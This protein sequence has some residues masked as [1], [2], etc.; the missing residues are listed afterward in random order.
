MAES[1][2]AKDETEGFALGTQTLL[3]GLFLLE[4]VGA[5]MS[6]IRTL[7]GRLGTPRTTTHR[8]LAN[9]IKAGY[10]R[11]P[12]PGRYILGPKIIALGKQ[13]LEQ[14]PLLSVAR[15]FLEA[16]ARQTGDTVHLGVRE[17]AEVFYLDK[18]PGSRGLEMRSRVGSCMPVASTG[19]G[20]ALLLDLDAPEWEALYA[21]AI[22]MKQRQGLSVLLPPWADYARD[23]AAHAHRGWVS[24]LEENELGVRCVAA[25]VRD[26]TGEI[27]AAI[28]VASAVP[29][30][31]LDRMASL[32]GEVLRCAHDI[33][34]IL[35]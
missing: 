32:G 23:M 26:R 19:V 28:S 8:T 27:I 22:E 3:R 33:S 20:R 1:E 24:D 15:P 18:I 7:S 31:P 4:C 13:A 5:G 30:M 35:D 29:Y 12:G 14:R 21:R 6:D 17:G 16:L 2:A 9:L 25:P 11:Q 10:L 34:A